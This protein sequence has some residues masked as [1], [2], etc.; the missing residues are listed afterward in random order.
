M[1]PND[2]MTPAEQENRDKA[3]A[4]FVKVWERLYGWTPRTFKF[5]EMTTAEINDFT[6][7]EIAEQ[8]GHE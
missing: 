4:R 3:A 5:D 6:Y 7:E 2:V 8:H 1:V